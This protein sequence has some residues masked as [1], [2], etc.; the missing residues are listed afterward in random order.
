MH[1]YLKMYVR[2]TYFRYEPNL[3][4]IHW[5]VFWNIYSK[6]PS[7]IFNKY[8]HMYNINIENKLYQRRD[9]ILIEIRV[10]TFVWCV[11]FSN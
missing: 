11:L 7:S 9:H 1:S 6:L 10:D 2:M 3:W 4:W 5:I 8:Q